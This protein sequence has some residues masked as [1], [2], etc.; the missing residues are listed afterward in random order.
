MTVAFLPES[1]H[2]VPAN[3]SAC[4]RNYHKFVGHRS[5]PLNQYWSKWTA[6]AQN[7]GEQIKQSHLALLRK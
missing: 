1:C 3:E 4:T 6:L 2:Q 5:I 7:S